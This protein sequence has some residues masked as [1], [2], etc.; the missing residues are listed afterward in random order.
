MLFYAFQIW[1][2][3]KYINLLLLNIIT[4]INIIKIRKFENLES[5]LIIHLLNII[6]SIN[7]IIGPSGFK[8][9]NIINHIL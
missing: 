1:K 7:N 9:R 2:F 5:T 3:G 6:T 4:S 8:A